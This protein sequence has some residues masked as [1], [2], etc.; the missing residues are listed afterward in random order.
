MGPQC[1]LALFDGSASACRPQWGQGPPRQQRPR[2][3]SDVRAMPSASGRGILGR[4]GSIWEVLV[5][6]AGLIA[7]AF[8]GGMLVAHYRVFPYP[9]VREADEAVWDWKANWRHYLQI[10][11]RYVDLHACRWRYRASAG[12]DGARHHL[13]HSLSRRVI[14]RLPGRSAGQERARIGFS[15]QQSLARSASSGP[16]PRRLRHHDHGAALLPDGSVVMNFDGAGTIK[17]D[18]VRN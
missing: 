10:R 2:T 14:P 11:S 12:A 3:M 16:R 15:L 6:G 17:I 5:F 1:D 9:F 13:R 8:V 4:L 18:S 7:L